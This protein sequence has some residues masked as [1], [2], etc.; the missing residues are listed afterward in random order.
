MLNEARYCHEA[1]MRLSSRTGIL[2]FPRNCQ[3]FGGDS[4]KN[5]RIRA[6]VAASSC[7]PPSSVRRDSLYTE[8]FRI[9]TSFP[10]AIS[11]V[12][13][14]A[15][16]TCSQLGYCYACSSRVPFCSR[17]SR[18]AASRFNIAEETLAR[19]SRAS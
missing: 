10:V 5:P 14:A 8:V 17:S 16:S 2:R 15:R 11:I 4:C 18:F 13:R 7:I 9:F 3:H 19:V 6:N 12:A 1:D